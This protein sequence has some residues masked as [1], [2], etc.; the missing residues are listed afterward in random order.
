MILLGITDFAIIAH[1]GTSTL[2]GAF[3]LFLIYSSSHIFPF[4]GLKLGCVL[5]ELHLETWCCQMNHPWNMVKSCHIYP[6]RYCFPLFWKESGGWREF[7][8]HETGGPPCGEQWRKFRDGRL[9]ACTFMC[10]FGPCQNIKVGVHLG[11]VWFGFFK[12]SNKK[13]KVQDTKT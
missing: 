8:S 11:E 4:D 10:V 5:L 2:E 7:E 9:S 12:I 1:W 3:Y 6:Y 13:W